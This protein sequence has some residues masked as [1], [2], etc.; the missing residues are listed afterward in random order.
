MISL[1][2]AAVVPLAAVDD[3]APS[4]LGPLR[5]QAASA[6]RVDVHPQS[7]SGGWGLDVASVEVLGSPYLIAHGMGRPVPDAVAEVE[8]PEAGEWQAWVRTRNWVVG[9]PGRFRLVVDGREMRHVFGCGSTNWTWEA[10][11]VVKLSKGPA[12]LALR[13]MSGFDGRCA[14]VVLAPVGAPA[15]VGALD[16]RGQAPA[17]TRE[18]D[19]VVVGGGM[20]GCCAAVAA[21]RA[22]IRTALVQDRPVLGGN[23]SSEV[24]VWCAGEM[25]H[26]LVEELR[27]LFMNR[28]P[29][30]AERDRTRLAALQRE[31]NLSLYLSHRAFA[32]ARDGPAISSVRAIDLAG[33]RVVAFRAKYFC[34]A[35][36]DG[37][38]G[39][40]AG[41]DYSYGREARSSTG[42]PSA[43]ERADRM[44]MGA[45]VMWDSALANDDVAFSAPWAEPFAED[46]AAVNGEWFW[47]YGHW[48]DMVGEDEAIRDRLLLAIYGAFSL[49]KKDP[50]N[51]RRILTTCPYVLGKRES[52][53]LAGDWLLKEDDVIRKVQFEDAIATGT[54]SVDLHFP[55]PTVPYMAKNRHKCY[56]RFY[57]PYRATYS[58][59]VPN[60]FMAGRCFSCTHA[61]LGPARVINTLSQ[62][63]VA[64]GTAAA[65]CVGKGCSPRDLFRNGH[66]RELQRRLG[67][68]WPGNPDPEKVGWLYVDDESPGVDLDG[69]W[70]LTHCL[71]GGMAGD[72]A[73]TSYGWKS[74]YAAYPLPV[75]KPGRYRLYGRIPYDWGYRDCAS[76]ASVTVSYEGRETSFQWRQQ[77]NTGRWNA[78]GEVEL[79][80]GARLVVKAADW[81]NDI[82][83]DGFALEPL[84]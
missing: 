47:E 2:L 63:G 5:A 50:V 66:V 64:V 75:E 38:I 11:D 28:N 42:E 55:H 45:S 3:T 52:R 9:A 82:V 65:M 46:G 12:V 74:N 73:H 60:L 33:S 17:V 34:D 4:G 58:R 41:A 49:A 27:G 84:R 70:I 19:F 26:P 71:N 77:V 43:P 23:A 78:I 24:R 81:R 1:L 15:P 29:L 79:G 21:A 37:W 14:G 6:V 31:P 7:F 53:R 30:A 59:N 83:V 16:V 8:I 51:S 44:V 56:G 69:D 32:V 39:Y 54:W 72:V 61:G 10:G 76:V 80:P 25:R 57:I 40:W 22:G 18:F 36:G 20:P 67:G 35:T 62:I 13:D 48:R 68:D